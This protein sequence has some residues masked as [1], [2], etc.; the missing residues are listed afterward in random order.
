M[1]LSVAEAEVVALSLVARSVNNCA[2]THAEVVIVSGVGGV[3]IATV[4]TRRS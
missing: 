1:K 3:V 2:V 4:S